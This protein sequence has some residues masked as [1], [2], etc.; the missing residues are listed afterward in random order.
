MPGVPGVS[1]LLLD[2]VCVSGVM[3]IPDVSRVTYLQELAG[4]LG[5]GD[6][7]GVAGSLDIPDVRKGPISL[8]GVI[9]VSGDSGISGV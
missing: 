2:A 4:S 6:V 9:A 3:G 8:L 1:D 7:P 5:V